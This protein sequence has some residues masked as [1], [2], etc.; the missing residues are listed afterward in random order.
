MSMPQILLPGDVFRQGEKCYIYLA[1]INSITHAA[2]IIDPSQVSQIEG[3]YK[4][5]ARGAGEVLFA[6][7]TLTTPPFENHGAHCGSPAMSEDCDERY[8][9]KCGQLNNEDMSAIVELIKKSTFLPKPLRESFA[10]V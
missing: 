3:V 4:L 5:Q 8:V 6:Y 10:Q 7:V 2:L 9:P 1:T